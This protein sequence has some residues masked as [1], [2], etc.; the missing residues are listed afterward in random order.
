MGVY[1]A[2]EVQTRIMEACQQMEPQV[3]A[4]IT[5]CRIDGKTV[6]AAEIPGADVARRPVYYRGIGILKGSYI[7][8]G[9]GD[10]P[11]TAYEIYSYEAYRKHAEDDF[12]DCCQIRTGCVRSESY[13]PVS[14]EYKVRKEKSVRNSG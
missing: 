6:V 10:L 13:Q 5:M 12:A 1:D 11:M 3:R 8:V 9:D 2:S 14:A 7:R 4:E